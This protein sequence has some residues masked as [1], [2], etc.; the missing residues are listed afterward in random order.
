MAL[1][2]IRLGK[3]VKSY[4]EKLSGTGAPA[5]KISVEE[6]AGDERKA[7]VFGPPNEDSAPPETIKTIN[8]PLG[9]GR[10][11]LVSVAY[12]NENIEPIAKPGERRIYSTPADGSE[13]KSEVYLQQ[14][15]TILIKNEGVTTTMT[16]TGDLTVDAAKDIR[17]ENP[18]YFSV[19]TSAGVVTFSTIGIVNITVGPF[20]LPATSITITPTG[21][22]SVFTTG[23]LTVSNIG[24]TIQATPTGVLT[25]V[26]LVSFTLVCGGV[27]L[28]AT[29]AGLLTITSVL[30]TIISAIAGLDITG[31][32]TIAGDL[33]VTGTNL[34]H[35]TVNVGDSHVHPGVTSGPSN[36]GGP[37]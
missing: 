16:P 33:A 19:K 7:Q 24:C 27:A 37:Q 13:V 15:G 6:F 1:R 14:D 26:S 25:V 18:G 11:F 23:I 2:D 28:Q 22:V 20:G 8:I 32:V 35:N 4:I 9:P 12:N 21:V 3:V 5:Q 17:E 10:G 30:K 34:T 31:P 36:T 29:A